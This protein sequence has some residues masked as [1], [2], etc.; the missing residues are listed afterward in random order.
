MELV[1]EG[2][3]IELVQVRVLFESVLEIHNSY[4]SRCKERHK[5]RE[6]EVIAV[7]KFEMVLSGTDRRLV[8]AAILADGFR[9]QA[10]T[11]A[12]IH[13]R[14]WGILAGLRLG[15]RSVVFSEM[16]QQQDGCCCG[17]PWMSCYLLLPV[18]KVQNGKWCC[19]ATE[20]WRWN[21][22]ST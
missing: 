16:K 10:T 14:F 1:L 18:E 4:C 9:I 2:Y 8:L 13:N 22:S 3:S 11:A 21:R 20:Q 6:W 7:A 5:V 19:T 17:R 15:V 12:T